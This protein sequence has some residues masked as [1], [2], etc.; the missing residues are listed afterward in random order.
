MGHKKVPCI[1]FNKKME[2][3]KME[4]EKV[5]CYDIDGL[6][7][8]MKP[9][10]TSTDNI[11]AYNKSQKNHSKARFI[12]IYRT[13]PKTHILVDLC[14]KK[15]Q[16]GDVI[17]ISDKIYRTCMPGL[18]K[19]CDD[20]IEI[21]QKWQ[22]GHNLVLEIDRELIKMDI[23]DIEKVKDFIYELKDKREIENKEKEKRDTETI[24]MEKIKELIPDASGKLEIPSV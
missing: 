20:S 4:E 6:M 21:L 13:Y 22:Y 7:R 11:E 19:Y 9:F 5:Y 23:V 3:Y 15:N 8:L 10:K 16:H 14:T 17:S 18:Y 2:V 1:F 12:S 24:T